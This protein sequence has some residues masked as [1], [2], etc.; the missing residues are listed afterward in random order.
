V[1]EGDLQHGPGPARQAAEEGGHQGGG[2]LG[3]GPRRWVRQSSAAGVDAQ[4]LTVQRPLQAP[5]VVQDAGVPDEAI[6]RLAHCGAVGRQ[7]AQD[8]QVVEGEGLGVVQ[9][10]IGGGHPATHFRPHGVVDRLHH[11]HVGAGQPPRV[12]PVGLQDA[13]DHR[14]L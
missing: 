3:D 12:E 10:E 7:V 13:G 6:E 1:A 9:A 4:V 5:G 8:R 11:P 14:A 2:E